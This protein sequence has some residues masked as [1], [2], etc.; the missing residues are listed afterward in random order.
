[1]N[2]LSL[3]FERSWRGGERQTVF[4]AIGLIQKG[5]DVH[6]VCRSGSALEKKAI[7]NNIKVYPL[8]STLSVLFF[9]IRNGRKFDILH[10]QGSKILTYCILSKPFHNAKI[11]FT[12]RINFRPKGRLTR[13]KYRLCDRIVAIS[14][15]V[16]NIVAEFS[17]RND[18]EIISDVVVEKP[19]HPNAIEERLKKVNPH[20]KKII[21]TIAA[22][23][24]E[25]NPL[26]NIEVV[27]LLQ[28]KRD[29]FIFL[30]FGEGKM[31][32][33]MIRLIDQYNLKD[34]YF[35]MGF[36]ENVNDYLAAMDVFIM[37]SSNEGLCSS[38]LDAFI[39]KVPVV[40][41]HAGGL[42]DLI[43]ENRGI[44][45]EINKPMMIVE[46]IDTIMNNPLL[47]K[48]QTERAYEYVIRQHSIEHISERY[49]ILIK[50]LIKNEMTS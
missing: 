2:I 44:T 36:V 45:C 10:A 1:M 39:Y 48:E 25:K 37:T 26:D 5:F 17:S 31:K 16:K 7:E 32:D 42:Q 49:A 46:G 19:I 35:L 43:N 9:L 28:Q 47:A 41:T 40:S 4:N 12:R 15:S 13:L 3:N 8:T 20:Q 27:R 11:I 50:S 33:E 18:V 14:S 30:H 38:V 23:T 21:G 6:L 22:L 24:S 34:T 29:D